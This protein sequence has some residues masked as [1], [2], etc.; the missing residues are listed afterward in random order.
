[1]TIPAISDG[2]SANLHLSGGLAG[3]LRSCSPNRLVLAT[4]AE[5]LDRLVGRSGAF[6]AEGRGSPV[7]KVQ[8]RRAKS[9]ASWPAALVG[10]VGDGDDVLARRF[11]R[12]QRFDIGEHQLGAP[13]HRECTVVVDVSPGQVDES[14]SAAALNCWPS[15]VVARVAFENLDFRLPNRGLTVAGNQLNRVSAPLDADVDVVAR[16]AIEVPGP[17]R[18]IVSTNLEQHAAMMPE[19]VGS[20]PDTRS[21]SGHVPARSEVGMLGGFEVAGGGFDAEADEVA[22]AA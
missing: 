8:R 19:R 3:C 11:G 10:E 4:Q 15:E 6:E 5:V 7:A 22:E 1:M 21:G 13:E 17:A 20:D 18:E 9:P 14:F 2:F 16:A 12:Y